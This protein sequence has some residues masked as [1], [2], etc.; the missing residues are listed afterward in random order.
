MQQMMA[1]ISSSSWD[2]HSSGGAQ[3]LIHWLEAKATIPEHRDN[4]KRSKY[5]IEKAQATNSTHDDRER[6]LG[7][8][9]RDLRAWDSSF[10]NGKNKM[11]QDLE[12][13]RATMSQLQF[14][15]AAA[16][17]SNT[18]LRDQLESEQRRTFVYE[19]ELM[20]TSIEIRDLRAES[21]RW[22]NLLEDEQRRTFVYEKEIIAAGMETEDMQTKNRRLEQQI[23]Q[24][25]G[26]ASAYR[27]DAVSRDERVQ[28]LVGLYEDA[29]AVTAPDPEAENGPLVR[30]GGRGDTD[31]EPKGRDM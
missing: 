27:R 8:K 30:D 24:F 26:E 19:K 28:R 13:A 23:Q 4:R 1:E 6:E 5:N 22:R 15:S 29:G 7:N 2:D 21:Q 14:Q 20:A 31:R 10:G 9:P 17:Q 12:A 25:V 11:H 3:D 18:G 16:L